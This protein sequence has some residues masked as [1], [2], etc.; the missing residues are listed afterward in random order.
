MNTYV[1][2][3]NIFAAGLQRNILLL[4]SDTARF[5]KT[6]IRKTD[7]FYDSKK[8]QYRPFLVLLRK[9]SSNSWSTTTERNRTVCV[10]AGN[11]VPMATCAFR[12]GS[13]TCAF[14]GSSCI[15]AHYRDVFNGRVASHRCFH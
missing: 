2:D 3:K 6:K 13:V 11:P 4:Q 1:F 7:V 9:P 10:N 15:V 14:A 12:N 5:A 8:K